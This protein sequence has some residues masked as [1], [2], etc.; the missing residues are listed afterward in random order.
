MAER[1][2]VGISQ[3]VDIDVV[4]DRG[5]IRRRIIGPIDFDVGALAE[6]CLDNQGNQVSL[7]VVVFSQLT[8][9]I[10]ARSVEIAQRHPLSA[11]A[12]TVPLDRPLH[13]E[14][15]FAVGVYRLLWVIFR[16]RHPFRRSIHC[17]RG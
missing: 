10:S 7:G 13:G 2:D 1:P 12:D 16:D 6:S 14:L 3:I 8:F 15:A 17:S 11:I 5:A 4:A 9:R